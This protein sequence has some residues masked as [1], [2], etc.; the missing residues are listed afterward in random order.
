MAWQTTEQIKP[1]RKLVL[2][3]VNPDLEMAQDLFDA[4][5]EI[6]AE[7]SKFTDDDNEN[8]KNFGTTK[9]FK[10]ADV[11]NKLVRTKKIIQ[12][13]TSEQKKKG[14]N[15]SILNGYMNRVNEMLQS[16]TAMLI[17]G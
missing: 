16:V 4:A 17:G 15:T 2:S 7:L 3:A 14:K 1:V 10:V 5:C 6:F 8:K 11:H 9:S 12:T 13:T